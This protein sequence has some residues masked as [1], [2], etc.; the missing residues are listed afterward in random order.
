MAIDLVYLLLLLMAFF[1]GLQHGLVMALFSLV[2]YVIALAAALK[3]SA[4]VANQLQQALSMNRA[5]LPFVSFLLVFLAVVLLVRLVAK[6]VETTL[7]LALLGWL[8]KLGGV[9]FYG[10]NFTVVYSILLFF[11]IQLKWIR[12]D[13]LSASLCYAY[14][15][16]WGPAL[17]KSLGHWIPAFKDVFSDLERFFEGVAQTID[18]GSGS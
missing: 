8:N 18:P 14:I 5:W 6:I 15:E 17:M 10:I 9:V 16:P 3:L 4:V 11:L 12:P 7:D 13:T 1:K 2:A